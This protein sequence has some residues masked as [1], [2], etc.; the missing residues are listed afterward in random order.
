[1]EGSVVVWGSVWGRNERGRVE[2]EER[3]DVKKG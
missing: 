1:M 2:E 3:E